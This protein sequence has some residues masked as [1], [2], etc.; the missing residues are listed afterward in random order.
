MFAR[1]L[2]NTLGATVL[3]AVLNF[4]IGW[5][6]TGALAAS[7]HQVRDAPTG[8]AN[9]AGNAS[10]RLV[11]DQS[12]HWTFT[13]VVALAVLTAIATFAV[14]IRPGFDRLMPTR[15]EVR[16]AVVPAGDIEG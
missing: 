12:L 1:S 9:L 3:G 7:V 13:T 4:G 11:F 15:R 14:P 6:G 2:G 8:L 10:A 16:D 5:F